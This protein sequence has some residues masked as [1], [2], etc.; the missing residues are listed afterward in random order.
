MCL[1][2]SYEKKYKNMNFLGSLNSP[3]KG[4]GSISKKYGFAD[5]DP[6]QNVTDPQHCLP[7]ANRTEQNNK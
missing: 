4:V 1:Q 7:S 6:H 5:L 2:I 3:K